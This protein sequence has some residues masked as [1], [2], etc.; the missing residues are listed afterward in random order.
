MCI[1]WLTEITVKPV[2]LWT[3]SAVRCRVPDSS[4][5]ID[6]SGTSWTLARMMRVASRSRMTAPSIFDSS[7]TP[8][9]L[10]STSR[11]KPPVQSASTARS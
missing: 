5:G 7:R 1:D 3:R 11:E 4:V 2:C 10:K 9:A 8:V 6:G